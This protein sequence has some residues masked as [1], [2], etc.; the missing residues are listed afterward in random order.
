[1][2]RKLRKRSK[3][4]EYVIGERDKFERGEVLGVQGV[5]DLIIER[6]SWAGDR[7]CFL[8]ADK[9]WEEFVKEEGLF[10][11]GSFWGTGS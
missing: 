4:Y 2:L 8:E 3:K 5:H 10:W 9:M 1:M 7:R 6:K 11:F